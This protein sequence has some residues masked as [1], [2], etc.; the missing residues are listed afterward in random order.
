[1]EGISVD[2]IL[3]SRITTLAVALVVVFMLMRGHLVPRSTHKEVREDRDTFKE[4]YETERK[5]NAVVQQALEDL[6]EISTDT[7]KV[8]RSILP[9]RQE[10][11]S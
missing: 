7:N 6:A 5:S 4:A 1:M 8:V 9:P 3:D 2:A 11:S 10:D